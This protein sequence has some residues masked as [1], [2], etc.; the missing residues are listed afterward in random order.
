MKIISNI[1]K[2]NFM[3]YGKCNGRNRNIGKLTGANDIIC[4]FGINN[5]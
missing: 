1:C 2:L 5:K 4:Q 3:G